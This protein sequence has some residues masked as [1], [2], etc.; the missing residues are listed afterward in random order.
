MIP[1]ELEGKLIGLQL[2]DG[3]KRRAAELARELESKGYEVIIS[4]DSC[5]GACDIDY[6][7]LEDVDLLLHIA[8][9]P[10]LK[11]KKIVYVPYFVD[12]D[13]KIELKIEEKRIA[14]ISTIQYCHKL[15]EVKEW[16]ESKGYEVELSKGSPRVLYPGQVL[17]CN[18]SV[19]KKTNAE[20]IVFIGDGLFHAIGASIYTKKKVY[21]YN[22]LNKQLEVVNIENFIKNRYRKISQCFGKNLAGVLV[23]K[24]PGQKRIEIA[25]KLKKIAKEKNIEAYLVSIDDV[26]EEKLLNLPFD[27]YINTACPR[28]TYDDSERFS[29]PIISPQ[30]FEFLLGLKECIELDEIG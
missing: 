16:L 30:E 3:L 12:Y 6:R 10:I 19:L 11:S 7:L 23:S 29:K 27:F 4:A 13:T 1:L 26:T 28:I 20:A 24:K 14:L 18:Y 17:G 22:P 2:P 9:T 15:Y 5:F 21:A 8:H 25:K